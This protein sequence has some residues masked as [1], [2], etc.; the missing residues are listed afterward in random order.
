[1]SRIP[2][3]TL[4]AVAFVFLFI[5]V[6]ISVELTRPATTDTAAPPPREGPTLLPTDNPPGPTPAPN[7]EVTATPDLDE[8]AE[9]TVDEEMDRIHDETQEEFDELLTDLGV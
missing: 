1:M 6:G 3:S 4:A 2:L 7:V 5:A 9:A 8:P